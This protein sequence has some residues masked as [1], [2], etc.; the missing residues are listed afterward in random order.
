MFKTL[1]YQ[2]YD[3]PVSSGICGSIVSFTFSM[4]NIPQTTQTL[5][6][7]GVIIKDIGILAGSTI[8]VASLFSYASKNWFK[9]ANNNNERNNP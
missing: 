9:K 6:L 2:I 7:V 5:E 4:I 3:H 1:F 8:A